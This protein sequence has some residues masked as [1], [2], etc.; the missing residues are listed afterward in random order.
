[1]SNA[2]IMHQTAKAIES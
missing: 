1:M 2:I